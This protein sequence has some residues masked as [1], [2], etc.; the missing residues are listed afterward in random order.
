MFFVLVWTSLLTMVKL[1]IWIWSFDAIRSY[2]TTHVN[3]QT[4]D[5]I[6]SV[7]I[8]GKVAIWVP[9][10]CRPLS[11]NIE[12][13]KQLIG[14]PHPVQL[15]GDTCRRRIRT[16]QLQY[17]EVFSKPSTSTNLQVWNWSHENT[18]S[19]QSH[20]L[21]NT[22]KQQIHETS[23]FSGSASFVHQI[24]AEKWICTAPIFFEPQ[25]PLLKITRMFPY[26]VPIQIVLLWGVAIAK[27]VAWY[28]N[29]L[30]SGPVVAGPRGNLGWAMFV[31]CQGNDVG[32]RYTVCI[33]NAHT[34]IEYKDVYIS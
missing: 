23:Q 10:L 32:I 9:C 3:L 18:K 15:I 27:P 16:R 6:I 24:S 1:Y 34:Y 31:V 8:C 25:N 22:Y 21:R 13:K 33:G 12:Y 4:G 26:I 11:M 29:C 19:C 17:L 14:A 30:R 20:T 7:E 28:P 5:Q 2:I